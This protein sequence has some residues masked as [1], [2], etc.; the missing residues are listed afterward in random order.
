MSQN[1]KP[2]TIRI[3]IN[4]IGMFRDLF[5][6]FSTVYVMFLVPSELGISLFIAGFLNFCRGICKLLL[7]EVK[8]SKFE[9]E[10]KE[11]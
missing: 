2:K 6:L 3:W 8:T 5:L 10:T 7:P 4:G 1:L 9:E 11:E